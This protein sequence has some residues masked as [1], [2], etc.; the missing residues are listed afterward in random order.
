[1]GA[2]P[3]ACYRASMCACFCVG[4]AKLISLELDTLAGMGVFVVV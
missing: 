2:S 3:A 1:M 4:A